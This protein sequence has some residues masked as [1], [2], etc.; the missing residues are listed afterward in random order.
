MYNKYVE[1]YVVLVFFFVTKFCLV[2]SGNLSF[3]SDVLS[4]VRHVHLNTLTALGM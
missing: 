1:D 2:M 3:I 4:Y